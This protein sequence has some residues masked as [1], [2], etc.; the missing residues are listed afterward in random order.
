MRQCVVFTLTK[1]VVNVVV[2]DEGSTVRPIAALVDCSDIAG[3]FANIVY[4]IEIHLVIVPG[5]EPDG[6]VWAIVDVVVD[7]FHPNCCG[8]V[9]NNQQTTQRV[10]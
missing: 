3:Q 10:P 5:E 2:T 1:K 6:I 9:S 7:N 4:M 8:R